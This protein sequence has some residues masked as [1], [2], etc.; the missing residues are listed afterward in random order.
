M[1]NDFGFNVAGAGLPSLVQAPK[2]TP[3][4]TQQFSP[5]PRRPAPEKDNKKAIQGALLGAI[6]PLLGEVAVRGLASIPGFEKFIYQDSPTTKKEY[7][8]TESTL[9]QS[10]N[11][12]NEFYKNEKGEM[13]AKAAPF[14]LEA[15]KRRA[16]V[17][18]ALP[19]GTVPKTKTLLGKIMSQ[20]GTYA[21]AAMLDE[22]IPEFLS[23][24]TSTKKSIDALDNARID[25]YLKRGTA[26]GQ[27]LI[28]IGDF[29][30][31]T[32][33]GAVLKPGDN[34]ATTV[35]RDMLVSPDKQ[36]R[37]LISLG[38]PEV[39]FVH[40][41]LGPVPVQA[42]DKYIR[43]D[44]LLDT[45]VLGA[46]KD[47]PLLVD[48]VNKKVGM[49]KIKFLKDTKGKTYSQLYIY[50]TLD[51]YK[52]K[53]VEK[54]FEAYGDNWHTPQPGY[55]YELQ[56][57]KPK[58]LQP[59]IKLLQD[60]SLQQG[61]LTASLNPLAKIAKYAI[62][63]IDSEDPST[64]SVLGGL[65]PLMV[66]MQREIDTAAMLLNTSL[67]D[68]TGSSIT[69]VIQQ[70]VSV[71]KQQGK[72]S[73]VLD[74]FA[75]QEDFDESLRLVGS[76]TK[77]KAQRKT[78]RDKY[79]QALRTL[80]DNAVAEDK[81]T[82]VSM[83]NLLAD[84]S[85]EEFNEIAVKRSGL[86][87]AQL[88][89]AYMSAAQDGSTGVALSDKDVVNYLQRVGFGSRNPKVVLEKIET[90]FKESIES[91]DSGTELSSLAIA[92]VMDSP[93]AILELDTHLRG[94]GVSSEQLKDLR[95]FSKNVE[96]RQ[97]LAS[98]IL[99]QMNKRTG[100]IASTHFFYDPV[101][102]RIV[103]KDI[104]TILQKQLTPLYNYFMEDVFSRKGSTVDKKNLFNRNSEA[105]DR[106]LPDRKPKK[107]PILK[108]K[109]PAVTF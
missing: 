39:D 89:L 6:S 51:N 13:R 8:L 23:T 64:F 103:L 99:V 84:A 77:I 65:A 2:I 24:A 108:R 102:G 101:R 3:V 15:A 38:D 67:I 36:T 54:M 46:D 96:E 35:R 81:N 37:Y 92:S 68:S 45:A 59:V 107:D 58:M 7:G 93:E 21:P 12:G 71:A 105:A 44:F 49:G 79:R 17:D 73:T 66:D 74:F 18:K 83:L 40:G 76:T 11:L 27:A 82:D 88:R 95:D 94:Y 19:P 56:T 22:G 86:L 98:D 34:R 80:R 85:E 60:R 75:A 48:D 57:L 31:A 91:F 69:S 70:R 53:T 104:E 30:T 26:R 25:N 55:A 1:A 28:D 16:L 63:S 4:R 78:A 14:E 29:T 41:K 100:G 42:G 47:V 87:S 43:D 97:E 109:G 62:D 9:G 33:N 5:T 106:F 50:D 52:L 90:V 72:N 20:L 32:G 61:A 10:T